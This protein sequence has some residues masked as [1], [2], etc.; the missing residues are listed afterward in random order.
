MKH[1]DFIRVVRMWC[2][3]CTDIV[4][5]CFDNPEWLNY[6]DLLVGAVLELSNWLRV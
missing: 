2:D 3:M 6:G 1:H 4:L 5:K